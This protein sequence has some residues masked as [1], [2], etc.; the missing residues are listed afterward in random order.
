M[1]TEGALENVHQMLEGLTLTVGSFHLA[2]KKLPTPCAC[3]EKPLCS[4]EPQSLP[5]KSGVPDHLLQCSC[6]FHEVMVGKHPAQ[7]MELRLRAL[8]DICRGVMPEPPA[9]TARQQNRPWV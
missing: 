7:H 3:P 5:F 4:C 2:L 9:D 6:E 1:D 8:V